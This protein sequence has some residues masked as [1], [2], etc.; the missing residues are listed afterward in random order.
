M[1]NDISTDLADPPRF[2]LPGAKARE[3]FD[4]ATLDEHRKKYADIT[5]LLMRKSPEAAF[6]QAIAV[7]EKLK[8]DVTAR[9]PAAHR[10]QAVDTTLIFRFKDDIAVR[11]S[12]RPDGCIVDVRS[13]SRV[14]KDDFGKNAKRIREFLKLL[15]VV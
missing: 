10:F 7:A 5:S 3:P 15:S 6:A 9:D 8:W 14:G 1:L 12:D 4:P 13:K 2:D 11:I